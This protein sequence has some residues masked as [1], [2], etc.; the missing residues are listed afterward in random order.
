MRKHHVPGISLAIVQRGQVVLAKGYGQAN[1]ELA[2]PAT[3]DTVYQLASVTKTFTAA[4]IM[5]LVHEGKLGLDD[6]VTRHLS[7]LPKAW[8]AVTVH[9]L[10]NHTSGIKSY[11]SVKDFFK[12][13]RKDYAQR[14]ILGLVA[15]EPLEFA[16]GEKW[17]YSN[18]GFF[19][20]GMLIET[21]TGKTYGEFLDERIFRPLRMTHTRINDLHAVIPNR[22][23]LYLERQRIAKWRIHEPQ[24]TVLG[25][26]A[27][28]ER[29]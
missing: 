13:I 26:D 15:R 21:V 6:K 18:S 2:V 8:D 9:Q 10:L 20:L 27:R 24:P 3:E 4:A 1:V 12:T 11:T 17:N 5:L 23:G 25:G 16:P 7:D 14:E 19:L 29:E 22:T 28:L